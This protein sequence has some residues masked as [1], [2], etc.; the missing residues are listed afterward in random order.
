[1]RL[2]SPSAL[3]DQSLIAVF[4][5]F[6]FTSTFSVAAG[7]IS[8]G[9]A[10]FLFLVIAVQRRYFPFNS[11]LKWF[12]LWA[13]LYLFWS[14][15][16]SQIAHSGLTTLTPLSR[17][18]L[19][20]LVP[21][22]IWIFQN[23]R[24][25]RLLFFAFALGIALISLYSV[26]QFFWGWNFLKPHYQ[27]EQHSLGYWVVGNFSN[28]VTFGIFYAVAGLFLLGYGLGAVKS[29]STRLSQL[30]V[31]AGGIAIVAA[32]LSNERGP[33]LAI[34][35]TLI[36][37]AFLF[38]SKRVMIGTGVALL[39][40]IAVGIQ[41]GV[42]VRSWD[43]MDKELSLRHDRSR[44][45]IWTHSLRVAFDHPMVGV[46]P[47]QMKEAYAKV[48]PTDI[49]DVTIQEHAHNDFL[50][51]AAESGFPAM[52]FL[53]ALWATVLGYCYR[54]QRSL[55]LTP[56]ERRL[57]LG[58]LAGSICF[59]VTSLFD[60]PFGHSSTRQMLMVVWAA[61]LGV[62]VKSLLSGLD[63]GSRTA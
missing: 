53:L 45:F 11:E 38:R 23:A 42:F 14:I 41:S 26:G 18:W 31:F 34:L 24:A 56:D 16:S 46:G 8:G 13:G 39:V 32:V 22:G 10:A 60:I 62:Y 4:I 61:G 21:T 5:V 28:S 57:A 47:G 49:P 59:F 7:S 58:G 30:A 55:R 35:L 2:T 1:M 15:L 37:I 50:M 36:T 3:L 25:T 9:V 17:E 33:T 54:A 29:D 48:V 63:V 40:I 52:A 12:Y 6:V 51:V 27:L 20:F 19:I 44:R 43:L